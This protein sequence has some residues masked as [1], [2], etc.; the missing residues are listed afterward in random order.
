MNSAAAVALPDPDRPLANR[1]PALVPHPLFPL[2]YQVEIRPRQL[3][4]DRRALD[5]RQG[6]LHHTIAARRQ[7]AFEAEPHRANGTSPW[8]EG[9]RAADQRQLDGLAGQ[10]LGLPREQCRGGDRR[11]VAAADPSTGRIAVRPFSNG[12]PRT[13]PGG[14]G[15]SPSGIDVLGP[16]GGA[17][18]AAAHSREY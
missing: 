7:N 14:F 5:P 8:A 17:I 11:L 10:G 2:F 12:R 6:N 1:P 9:P 4:R 18:P 13:R 15:V 3:P 16:T